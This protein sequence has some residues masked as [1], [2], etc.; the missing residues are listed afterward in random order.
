MTPPAKS[1]VIG[2]AGHI[3]HGKTALI[4]ALTG[5]DADRLPE[6]KR[7]GITIDLGFAFLD[8][9]SGDGHPLRISFVDVPGHGLFIHN[10]LAG[11]GCIGAVLLVISA[12]EGIKP[13]TVEHLAICNL[14]GV[15]AGL[16]VI[17][18]MDAVEPSRLAQVELEVKQFLRG[19][20]L[21]PDRAEV[22]AVSALTGQNIEVLRQKLVRLVEDTKHGDLDHLA[23]L[24]I[25]RAFVMKGFGTVVTGTL[26]SGS[27]HAA[28][29]LV[30]EPGS[31][32]VR[33]R[34]IQTHSQ[35]GDL[36][37]SG[38]RVALN[39]AGI[40]VSE[41][42]RGQTLV[43]PET[44]I[45]V[46][47]IDV[48]AW[49]LPGSSGVKH[50]G[51]VHFHAFT[52]N[53]MASVLLYDRARFEPGPARLM[54]MK[55]QTPIVL[56]PGDRFVLR[57]VSPPA[58]IGGGRV[59]DAHPL[60]RLRKPLAMAWLDSLRTAPGEE[61][62]LLRVARRSTR[63]LSIQ[64]LMVETGLSQGAAERL[65][66]PLILSGRLFQI[67]GGPL[68]A[69]PALEAASE[70][71]SRN[72][73]QH[74]SGLKRSE[75]RTR[76]SISPEIFDFS[77]E[78]LA[79]ANKLRFKGE[80]VCPPEDGRV[81]TAAEDPT[82]SAIAAIYRKAGLAAPSQAEIA[83]MLKLKESD[84]RGPF[85]LLLREKVLVRMGSETLFVHQEALD[86]L[87]TEIKEL[88]GQMVDV[89]RFKQITGLSRKYAIPLLEYL[90]RERITRKIGDQRL[91]L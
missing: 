12:Q 31:R 16:T 34:G 13:Q 85:T 7:R 66:H 23:R 75:L 43:A 44:L 5:I 84:L 55:L 72:L 39:L 86:R 29:S 61:Q 65:L 45:A 30:V 82:L 49:L 88:R 20:F 67:P 76:T 70:T 56:I 89:G 22:L 10:M 78:R 15:R 37:H 74:A 18:K 19:T 62:L 40:E 2:T 3:D 63:G 14:L 77:L 46:N 1:V 41:V 48:Q 73:Q 52:S 33:V 54:R 27:L 60:P 64:R 17:T 21:D 68:V 83:T 69:G 42:G 80:L 53:T 6:E 57:Q 91:V 81:G 36:V 28:Q 9:A 59:L 51:L 50:G 35:A 58:T 24:P 90:D 25:D 26:L 38:S 8:T 11:T 47:M 79:R 87:R 32:T 4:R 71:I